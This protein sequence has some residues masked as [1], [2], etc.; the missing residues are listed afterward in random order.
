MNY[1]KTIYEMTKKR[2]MNTPLTSA[3]LVIGLVLSMLTIS[4]GVSFIAEHMKAQYDKENAQPPNGQQYDLMWSDVNEFNSIE[5]I[6]SGIRQHTGVIINGLM[7]HIDES[8]V[9]TYSSVSAEWFTQD[10]GWHYPLSE[11]RYYT[12]D[13][14]ASG[15]KVVL[16]GKYYKEYIYEENGN[17]YIDIENE[18]YQVLGI[19]GFGEQ[20]SLWDSRVFMPCTSLPQSIMD[21]C[22]IYCD[23]NYILYNYDGSFVSDE[24]KIQENAENMFDGSDIAYLGEI[25]S[26]NMMEDLMNSQDMIYTIAIVGYLVSLVYA[27]NIVVFWMEKRKREIGIRKA[28]GYTNRDITKLLLAEMLGFS[29]IS[30]VMAILIQFVLK[31]FMGSLAGYTLQIYVANIVIGL[32][33]ILLTAVVTSILPVRKMLKIQPVEA[34]KKG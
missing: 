19:V 3:F 4:V 12:K 30:F 1:I 8:Q 2:I 17:E 10:E 28:L 34:L 23:I 18:K 25:Q 5:D 20:M 9:N 7:V 27:I 22:F 15:K 14:V 11:G 21:E 32:I 6:F 24:E 16:V 29:V 33:M 26:G 31:I 13:E